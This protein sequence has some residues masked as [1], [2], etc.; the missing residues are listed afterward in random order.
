MSDKQLIIWLVVI[1][2]VYFLLRPQ[3]YEG[4]PSP[5]LSPQ[6]K[7]VAESPKDDQ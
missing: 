2:V 6:R 4:L 5:A 1:L 3:S 7:K